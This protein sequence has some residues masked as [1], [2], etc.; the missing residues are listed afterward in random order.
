M[1]VGLMQNIITSNGEIVSKE[2]LISEIEGLL[3]RFS[4]EDVV[5]VKARDSS[6]S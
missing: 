2:A 4:V 5:A 1:K 3:N 6:E